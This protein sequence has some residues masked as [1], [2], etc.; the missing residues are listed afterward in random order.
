L[1]PNQ[2][3][4]PDLNLPNAWQTTVGTHNR[5][6]AIVDSG[7]WFGHPDLAG[8][9]WTAADGS[10][11]WNCV[12]S[13]NN[14]A[15]DFGHG[16]LVAGVAAAVINNGVGIVGTAQE[17]L[18]SVK[19]GSATQ[20]PTDVTEACGIQWAVDHGASVINI[21]LGGH[22]TTTLSNAVAYAWKHG[23]LLVAPVG[24]SGTNSID[25][26]ACYGEVIPVS[27]LQQ[28]DTN[29]CFSNYGN[30]GT[31][32]V[33]LGGTNY[34]PELTAPGVNILTTNWPLAAIQSTNFGSCG[35]NSNPTCLNQSYCAVDGTSFSAPFVSGIAALAWDYNIQ[36]GPNTF[37]NQQ[38]RIALDNYVTA[39]SSA[40]VCSGCNNY[41]GYGKPDAS[42]LLHAMNSTYSYTL[43]A[44][45]FSGLSSGTEGSAGVLLQDI[46][47]PSH[48]KWITPC[49]TVPR[50]GNGLTVTITAG[51][52]IY[53]YFTAY[54]NDGTNWV[55]LSDGVG[56]TSGS[57]PSGL[58]PVTPSYSDATS[59]ACGVNFVFPPVSGSS[60]GDYVIA[61]SGD[62]YSG[63]SCPSGGVAK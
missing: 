19:V 24:N 63:I 38:V 44:K 7:I 32:G 16:T 10:H 26:P 41:Y 37:T 42:A 17:W 36:K 11:G 13:N 52:R 47:D 18:M 8:N 2:W 22:G 33:P 45:W 30:F 12:A 51:H 35:P 3:A 6:I 46:T 43:T 53:V 5:I 49:C 27:A 31:P 28:G 20:L 4:L 34:G 58:G 62:P 60:Q 57:S 59:L 55:Y 54:F 40:N 29:A 23:A 25:C 21:S 50:V 1:Y 14:A 61:L 39:P 15:D 48:W 9:L 56:S